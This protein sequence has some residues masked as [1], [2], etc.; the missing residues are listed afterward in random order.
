M[1]EEILVR[2]SLIIIAEKYLNK[3]K[4]PHLTMRFQYIKSTN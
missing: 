1:V 2:L 3:L 4:K